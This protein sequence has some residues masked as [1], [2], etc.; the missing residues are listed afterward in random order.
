MVHGFT[1][2]GV[3]LMQGEESDNTTLNPNDDLKKIPKDK[4]QGQNT[5]HLPREQSSIWHPIPK[6]LPSTVGMEL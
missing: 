5:T 6:M 3:N 2:L 4:L 1:L